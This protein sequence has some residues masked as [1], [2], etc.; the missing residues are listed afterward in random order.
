[1]RH[2]AR[3]DQSHLVTRSLQRKLSCM[4]GFREAIGRAAFHAAQPR[5]AHE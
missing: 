4:E 5:K 2:R 1:M 3:V